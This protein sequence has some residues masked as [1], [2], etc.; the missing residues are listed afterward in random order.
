[1]STAGGAVWQA[2]TRNLRPFAIFFGIDAAP[3]EM[4]PDAH[5]RQSLRGFFGTPDHHL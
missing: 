5:R 4:L 1:M 3:G 2:L